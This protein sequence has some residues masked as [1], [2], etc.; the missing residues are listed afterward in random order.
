MTNRP[1]VSIEVRSIGAARGDLIAAVAAV[2][3]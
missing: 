3:R 1:F 2:L